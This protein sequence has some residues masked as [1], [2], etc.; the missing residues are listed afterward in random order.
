VSIKI[1]NWGITG[2]EKA[3]HNFAKA[4]AIAKHGKL[5]AIGSRE[6]EKT[7]N[8]AQEFDMSLNFSSYS[9]LANNSEVDIVYIAK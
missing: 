5:I 3:T 9:Q 2:T 1:V 6:K 4:L 7:K 8:F